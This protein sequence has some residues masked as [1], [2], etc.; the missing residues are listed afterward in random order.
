MAAFRPNASEVLMELIPVLETPHHVDSENATLVD[1][2]NASAHPGKEKA[3]TWPNYL[4]WLKAILGKPPYYALKAIV[5]MLR[6]PIVSSLSS[7]Q[8]VK[9]I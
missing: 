5:L 4:D 3:F 1:L 8:F 2:R 7:E 6:N 9:L